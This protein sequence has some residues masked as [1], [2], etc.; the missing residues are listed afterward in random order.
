[1]PKGTEGVK[2]ELDKTSR[3]ETALYPRCG[4]YDEIDSRRVDD[5]IA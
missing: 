3:S 1:M 2:C 4:D 5:A